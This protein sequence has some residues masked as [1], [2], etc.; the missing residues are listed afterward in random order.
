[1]YVRGGQPIDSM[2]QYIFTFSLDAP[3]QASIF[4][5]FFKTRASNIGE[6]QKK[7][8]FHALRQW[9]TQDLAKGGQNRGSEGETPSRQRIFTVFT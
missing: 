7:S 8:S 9:R 5:Q 6:E 3:H 4:F 1:M 2:R